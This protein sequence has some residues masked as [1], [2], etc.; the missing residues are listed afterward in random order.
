M[1]WWRLLYFITFLS[2]IGY[3]L[4]SYFDGGLSWEFLPTAAMLISVGLL[5]YIKK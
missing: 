5:I 4:Y 3:S 1:E 2:F